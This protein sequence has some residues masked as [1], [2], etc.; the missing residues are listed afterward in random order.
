[1]AREGFM[2]GDPALLRRL[3]VVAVLRALHA[4]DELTFTE[5]VRSSQLSRPTVE[6][7]VS[8]LEQ[9]GL[10][11]EVRPAPDGPRPVGRP[12]KR[13]RFRPEAGHLAGVDIGPHKVLCLV[14]DLRGDIVSSARA[15]VDPE[16]SAADR[17]ATARTVIER[18]TE[19]RELRALGVGTTGVV[20]GGRVVVS[21]RLP[22]W[23]G[24][25][26]AGELG[27]VGRQVLVGNDTKLAALAE[28]WRGA[29]RSV[30]DVIYL[31]VGRSISVGVLIGGRLH[32]GHHGGAGEIGVLREVGWYTALDR[33][34]SYG[35]ERLF[36]AVR[37]GDPEAATIVTAFVKDLA[38][39]V[40]ATVLTVDPQLVVIGGG[41]SQAGDLLAEPLRAELSR[42]CLFPVQVETSVLGDESVALGA[43]RLALD[44]V[45]E[46]LFSVAEMTPA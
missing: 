25:D 42:L 9:Q 26:L 15:E 7:I 17:L 46:E 13:Y 37:A 38:T 29:A 8:D 43:V 1:M 6:E 11:E 36:A 35:P 30:G 32:L 33:V 34:R 12:A 21:D 16:M 19:G 20:S 14:T 44:R 22:D 3:N 18:A 45:E 31:L 27:E 41:L 2:I 24:L 5:L 4:A 10:A 40:A 28:H 39:G 23:Q